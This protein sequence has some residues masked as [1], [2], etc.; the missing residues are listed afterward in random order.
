MAVPYIFANVPGG[1]TIP[2]AEID[3]NFAYLSYSPTLTNLSVTGNLSVGQEFIS[4]GPAVFN[5]GLA[6]IGTLGVN[7]SFVTPTGTTGAGNLVLSANPTLVAP[8]LAEGKKF[9]KL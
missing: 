4:N 5:N 6:F 7:G 9:K 2:L 1:T 8:N 3:A